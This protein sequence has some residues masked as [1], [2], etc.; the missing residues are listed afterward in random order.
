PARAAGV[1]AAPFIHFDS[2]DEQKNLDLHNRLF[3]KLFENGI[4]ANER[5]FINFSHQPLD[6][7]QTLEALR[8]A[9]R[10]L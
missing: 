8:R 7:E 4:F 2:A 9:C 1:P 3:A 10:M 5:W 6:I